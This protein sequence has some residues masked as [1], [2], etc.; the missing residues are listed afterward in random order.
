MR[1]SRSQTQTDLKILIKKNAY[2]WYALSTSVLYSGVSKAPVYQG[3]IMPF[4]LPCLLC[5]GAQ[6][7]KALLIEE[8]VT[9]EM[10]LSLEGRDYLL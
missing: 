2:T 10:S 6:S 4:A 8:G 9:A 7:N 1:L 3:Y 5:C